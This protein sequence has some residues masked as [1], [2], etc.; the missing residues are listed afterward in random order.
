MK[1]EAL[2]VHRQLWPPRLVT[3]RPVISDTGA[4]GTGAAAW[5]RVL[6]CSSAAETWSRFV[7]TVT[8]GITPVEGYLPV[9]CHSGVQQG[10]TRVAAAG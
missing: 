8:T 10:Q 4:V 6:D 3:P 2:G 9:R 1:V 7:P 5:G